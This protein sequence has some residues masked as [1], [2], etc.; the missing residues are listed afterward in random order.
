MSPEE[1]D[2]ASGRREN[3][4]FDYE[5]EVKFFDV[6]MKL[7]CRVE[8]LYPC[9]ATRLENYLGMD[10]AEA[11]A[12]YRKDELAAS[13]E[14]IREWLDSEMTVDVFRDTLMQYSGIKPTLDAA[15]RAGQYAQTYH[16]VTP[17]FVAE[18]MQS[19]VAMAAI[20]TGSV[21][22]EHAVVLEGIKRSGN[23]IIV[24]YFNPALK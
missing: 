10:I 24:R 13:G 4:G 19:G 12:R 8:E 11:Y 6:L 16:D 17:E 20:K 5:H 1:V 23:M 9:D 21:E 3:E 22:S 7:G 2:L 14:E 18:K 15:T